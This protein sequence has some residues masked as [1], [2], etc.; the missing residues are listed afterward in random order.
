M[1]RPA[2]QPLFAQV[3]PLHDAAND[4]R[5]VAETPVVIAEHGGRCGGHV[6]HS[7]IRPGE[8]IQR[9]DRRWHHAEC[10]PHDAVEKWGRPE[11]E[12]A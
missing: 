5:P 2:G 9:V 1:S 6:C 3:I 12:A 7:P 10:V 8:E 11:S 4:K